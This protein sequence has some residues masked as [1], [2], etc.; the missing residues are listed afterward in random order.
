MESINLVKKRPFTDR[1][2]QKVIQAGHKVYEKTKFVAKKLATNKV[3][4]DK[5]SFKYDKPKAK[6][7]NPFGVLR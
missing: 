3:S 6:T 7:K 4:Y 2:K 1:A 5:P